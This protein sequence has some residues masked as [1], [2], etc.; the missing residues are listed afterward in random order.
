MTVE[1]QL[2]GSRALVTGGAGFVG[3]HI[4]ELL[5][6]SGCARVI[7]VDN[8][9]RGREANL[10]ETLQ[11]GRVDLVIGDVRDRQLMERLISGCDLV[12]HQAALRITHC[13]AEPRLALEVM[14]DATFDLID[15]CVRHRVT[16]LVAASSA[17]IYGL[18]ENFP[19]D[20]AHHPYDNRTLYGAAKLFNESLLRSFHDTSGLDYVALRYFNVYG[21]RMD[22]YGK[23]TEVLIRWMERLEAGQAPLIFGSGL[24]TMDFVHVRDVARANLLAANSAVTDRVFNIGT[25]VESSLLDLAR[26]LSAVFGRPDLTPEFHPERAINPVARRLAATAGA[27]AE[28]SFDAKISLRDGL[29]ELVQ[30]W[31]AERT[32]LP[33]A[34]AS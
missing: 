19:T 2:S 1:V 15:L 27:S 23:Y 20:E 28:L 22:I 24:Q 25:G 17:S 9:I 32:G 34:M 26:E 7:V 30:W 10:A 13:A 3:S 12:F 8:M 33:A 31:R 4:V 16:K 18:A 5:L 11:S 6:A 21:P 29:A 14:V